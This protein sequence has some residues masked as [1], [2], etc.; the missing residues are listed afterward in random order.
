MKLRSLL[1]LFA[2]VPF[3][4]GAIDHEEERTFSVQ[5]GS[6]LKV[7]LYRGVVDI[8]ETDGDEIIV[9]ALTTF[10]VATEQKADELR[11]ALGLELRQEGNTVIVRARDPNGRGIRLSLSDRPRV[12]LECRILVPRRCSVDLRTREGGITVGNL[13]GR[14]VARTTKG[15]VF[16]RRIDGT[17]DVAAGSGDVI[18][19]RCSGEVIAK[20]E[21]GVL[22]VG[23]LGSRAVLKNTGG[24]IEVL[25]AHAG[26][27]ATAEV[28]DVIVGLPNDVAGETNIRTAYGSI[29][30]KIDPAANCTVRASSFWGHVENQLPLTIASGGNGRKKLAGKLNEGGPVVTLHANGGHVYLQRGD[31]YFE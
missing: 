2:L 5:P 7:E 15:N 26:L 30:A 6:L 24:D 14:V 19:S 29:Y 28:G 31:T 4:V 9:T 17:I 13:I 27:D 12:D 22:R 21:Q 1:F 18:I 11:A 10:D 25:E 3:A 20:T 16:L 23:T 8:R